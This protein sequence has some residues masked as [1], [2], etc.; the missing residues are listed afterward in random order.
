MIWASL[1]QAQVTLS[2]DDIVTKSEVE[3]HIRFL[4]SDAL[5]GRGNNSPEIEIA[6][7]YIAE[8]FRAYGADPAVGQSYFQ[9]IKLIKT[10]PSPTA[11]LNIG[12]NRLLQGIDMVVIDGFGNEIE[13]KSVFAGYGFESD[14]EGL[15]VQGRI[16][17]AR[18]GSAENQSPGF[19]L[20]TFGEK[21][22][23][24]REKGGLALVELYDNQNV[25]WELIGN[26]LSKH[27][28]ARSDGSDAGL[29]T[30]W[31]KDLD[32]SFLELVRKKKGRNV[33]L[34]I[35]NA[36]E[37]PWTA[38]NVLGVV[39]GQDPEMKNEYLVL[40]AHYDHMGIGAP[41]NGDSIYNGARDN[42][43]GVSAMLNA[44]RYL[45]QNPPA[46]SVIFFACAAEE[47][48]M[49]GS[50]WYV[51][52][53]VRPLNQTVFNLNTDGA[54]YN[55]ISKVTV[56]G[57][58]RNSVEDLIR[59]SC[60]IYGLE[61]IP[62]PAPEQNLFNRSDNV[63]F[64]RAG[65]PAVDF[66][67][68]LTAFDQEISK[69]YHQPQDEISSLDLDYV[70]KFVKALVSTAEKIANHPQ[71]PTWTPGDKYE[72]QSKKLYLK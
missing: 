3:A 61:A 44:V 26:Y 35:P 50:K 68:G 22:E 38:K 34:S 14:L 19:Y 31:V 57:L 20:Q 63:H 65:I 12:D 51:N 71:T 5:R 15:S 70:H 23:L 47:V 36:D 21:Q 67:P 32:G 42:G 13:G 41:V 17:F 24:I 27:E 18:I 64:A 46:R 45:S 10:T 58:G 54:G 7:E 56:V 1:A 33:S 4:A 8:R 69:Y 52:N 29:P 30:V 72:E 6:A 53:P 40:S 62:D 48:G 2:I 28:L 66:A 49:L 16:V 11:N 25:P 9:E 59:A 55:D 37:E 39:E 60:Q 43:I